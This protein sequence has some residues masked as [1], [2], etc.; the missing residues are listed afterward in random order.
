M[1]TTATT[2]SRKKENQA[3][4]FFQSR[5]S[6]LVS[7][8]LSQSLG[9]IDETHEDSKNIIVNKNKNNNNGDS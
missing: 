2:T 3:E 6:T 7:L 5:A 4:L 9:G 8:S 1:T